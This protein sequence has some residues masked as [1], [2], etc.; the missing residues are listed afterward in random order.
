MQQGFAAE[1][2]RRQE[3]FE[4]SEIKS[5]QGMDICASAKVLVRTMPA[6]RR[7]SRP[8]SSFTGEDVPDIGGSVD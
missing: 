1:R 2:T 7:D 6:D 4:A 8:D 5:G 3:D